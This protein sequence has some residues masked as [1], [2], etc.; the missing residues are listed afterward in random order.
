[1]TASLSGSET[2]AKARVSWPDEDRL[3]DGEAV[4]DDG[5]SRAQRDRSERV[6]PNA[7]RSVHG[8]RR[9]GTDG[10]SLRAR[11]LPVAA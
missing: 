9:P 10:D 2:V 4:A 8:R 1:M 6:R 5:A 3:D 11:T 7:M